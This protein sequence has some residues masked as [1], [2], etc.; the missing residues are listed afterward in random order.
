MADEVIRRRGDLEIDDNPKLQNTTW[1][2]E[3]VAWV[4]LAL[5]LAAALLGVFG[6]GP[7]SRGE[8]RT[9]D[10]WLVVD[11][12]RVARLDSPDEIELRL[13]PGRPERAT[14]DLDGDF[15]RNFVVE[16]SQ[17][18]PSAQRALR[19]GMS[20]DFELPPSG[21]EQVVVLHVRPRRAAF[22]M[23]ATIGARG[24]A[25]TEIATVVLP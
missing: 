1:V 4:L 10:G 16:R 17:P 3:R 25:P 13:G 23:R 15:S 8:A 12:P 11:Y 9:A 18:E 6:H 21:D 20:L 7:L 2:A 19:A 22:P 5:F 24:S 14:I